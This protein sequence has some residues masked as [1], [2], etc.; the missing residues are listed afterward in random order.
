MPR[1]RVSDREFSPYPE[2]APE[3]AAESRERLEGRVAARV[4]RLFADDPGGAWVSCRVIRV[5]WDYC[6]V[7]VEVQS[8]DDSGAS[9]KLESIGG[10]GSR[11]VMPGLLIAELEEKYRC[12][13]VDW[14]D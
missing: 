14:L 10:F 1:S 4:R 3:I 6:V 2:F 7:R 11:V 9:R 5:D 13:D 12:G 8:D